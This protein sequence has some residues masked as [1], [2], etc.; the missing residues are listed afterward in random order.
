MRWESKAIGLFSSGCRE[1]LPLHSGETV[2]YTPLFRYFPRA[3][4]SRSTSRGLL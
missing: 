3:P 1:N 2:V 4:S